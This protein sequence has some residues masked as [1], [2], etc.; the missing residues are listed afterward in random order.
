MKT[1]T[2]HEIN[3]KGI[4]ALKKVLTPIELVRFFQQYEI[5]NGNYT[6]ERKEK[7]KNLG[8]DEISSEIK[9]KKNL[10]KKSTTKK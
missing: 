5:G 8:I 3:M 1:H 7:Y 9:N 6:E 2:L 10:K 4:Q